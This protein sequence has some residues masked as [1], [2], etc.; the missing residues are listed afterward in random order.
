MSNDLA[1]LAAS[2]GEGWLHEIVQGLRS[3]ERDIVG[4]WPGTL[5]EA[6][7]RVLA[8]IRSSTQLEPTVVDDLARM[9]NTAARQGWQAISEPDP[10]A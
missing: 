7:L 4:A 10:E 1:T 6:R 5:R 8:G 9:A 2:I 3:S